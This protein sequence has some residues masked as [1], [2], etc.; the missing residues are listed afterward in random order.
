M[1]G[2]LTGSE[3][4]VES[5]GGVGVGADSRASITI[6]ADG[7]LSGSGGCNRLMGRADIKGEA[8][9]FAP[10]QRR[11]WRVRR[12]SCSRNAS[13]SM[14]CRRRAAIASTEAALTLRDVSGAELM[15]L[16]RRG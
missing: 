14:R 6:A 3:W 9:T 8:V 5:I 4:R 7:A 12:T 1:A 13:C 11:G 16:A 15:R 2:S 10:S